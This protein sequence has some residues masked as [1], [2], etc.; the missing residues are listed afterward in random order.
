M[1]SEWR[2]GKGGKPER[3]GAMPESDWV[4]RVTKYHNTGGHEKIERRGFKNTFFRTHVDD[5]IAHCPFYLF[6]EQDYGN[7]QGREL[8][9]L[10]TL[11]NC[12]WALKYKVDLSW[13]LLLGAASGTVLFGRGL[14]DLAYTQPEAPPKHHGGSNGDAD[15]TRRAGGKHFSVGTV[16]RTSSTSAEAPR[17][18]KWRRR[19]HQE[20]RGETFLGRHR[21]Q[22]VFHKRRSTTA[23]QMATQMPPGGPGGNISRSAPSPGRLPQAPKH[24]GGSNGDADATRRAGG[25]HFSVGTVAR[26]SSTSAEAPRRAK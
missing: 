19:C 4:E 18:V 7:L 20:G 24:H 9:L 14:P 3:K 17:R 10:R 5:R 22:D 25:K 23:G 2:K 26:T 16:A 13:D 6:V 12:C 15:A 8:D 1:P 21:R 11:C